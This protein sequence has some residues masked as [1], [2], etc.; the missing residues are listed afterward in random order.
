LKKIKALN[1]K[2]L[3][4]LDGIGAVFSAFMLGIVLIKLEHIFGIPKKTLIILATIPC[5]FLLYDIY[6]YFTKN[7]STSKK[8]LKGIA[9]LN[10]IYCFLSIGL[11]MF[12]MNVI[13]ALGWTY[14][15]LEVMV[16]LI[17]VKLEMRAATR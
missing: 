1:I 4:L 2:S 13:T 8:L 5:F 6:G 17:I 11:A 16:I 14:I 10:L 9:Y 7:K 12:H 15:I 3:F